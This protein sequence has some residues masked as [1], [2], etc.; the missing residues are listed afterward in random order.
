MKK[1]IN[2]T[3]HSVSIVNP[4]GKI[5]KVFEV[6]GQIARCS[7]STK[8]VGNIDGI[9]LTQT[10]FGDVVN[11]PQPQKDTVFIVS[12]LVLNACKGVRD[13]LIVPNDLVRDDKGNIIGCNS[14]A[15]N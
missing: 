5:I 7:Q 4:E 14:F 13:D 15:I 8:I 3:P 11:L 1:I 10:T 12:R 6:S 9:P 2:L